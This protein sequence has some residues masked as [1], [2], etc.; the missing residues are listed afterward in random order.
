MKKIT[1]FLIV[2]PFLF[3]CSGGDDNTSDDGNNGFDRSQILINWADNII[4]PSYE[5]YLNKVTTLDNAANTFTENP[6]S[7]SL[8]EI[9]LAAREAYI[10]WEKV[11]FFEFGPAKNVNFRTFNN[12]Y[13]TDASGINSLVMQEEYQLHLLSNSDKQGLPA[14]DY[15]LNGIA[16]NDIEI[17][18]MYNGEYADNYKN[19]LK[20]ITQKMK[21]LISDVHNQW[22]N[23][24]RNSFVA[25]DGSSSSAAVDIVANEYLL[26]YE[27]FMR[28]GKIRIPSGL[29]TGTPLP[30]KVEAYYS[31]MLGKILL[32]TS[33]QA[34]QDFFNGKNFSGTTSQHSFSNYLEALDKQTLKDDINSIFD[35]S[36]TAVEALGDNLSNE[37]LNNNNA[38]LNVH[39]KIQENVVNLKVNMMQSMNIV[40]AY[41]DGDG[42]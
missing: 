15:L 28:N 2:L 10:A 27:K 29:L 16:T 13:P 26:Y 30:E 39:D 22:V 4:L 25:N 35:G 37:M 3:S 19:L 9:Q 5:N 31:P 1:I 20:T 6:S 42:D 7:V 14:V 8:Q 24:Y 21:T 38:V 12:T 36:K 23:E 34:M 41:F 40:V 33:I 32:T 11:A 18:N 17:L